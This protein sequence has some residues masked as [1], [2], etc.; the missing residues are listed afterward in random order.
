LFEKQLGGNS[1]TMER[2]N[3]LGSRPDSAWKDFKTYE[4]LAIN[5]DVAI[6]YTYRP[7]EP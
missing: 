6:A 3:Y 1:S 2:A 4:D 7:D 5:P